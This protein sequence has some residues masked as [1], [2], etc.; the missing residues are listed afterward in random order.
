MNDHKKVMP[1]ELKSQ[2]SW[3]MTHRF[4]VLLCSLAVIIF[5]LP[6]VNALRSPGLFLRLLI[7]LCFIL[8]LLTALFA[9]SRSKKQ[10]ILAFILAV[11]MVILL[12]L[13]IIPYFSNNSLI[14]LI[15]KYMRQYFLSMFFNFCLNFA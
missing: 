5:I 2:R 1:K 3:V 12:S 14:T 11:P 9:V 13:N 8:M 15:I 6:I 10:L 7:L 4:A